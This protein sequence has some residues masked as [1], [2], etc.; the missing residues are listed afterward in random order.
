M[1]ILESLYLLNNLLH[2]EGIPEK[3]RSQFVG[4]CLLALKNGVKYE[5]RTT[6]EIIVS[7]SKTLEVLLCGDTKKLAVIC[8]VLEAQAI[9]SLPDESFR[10]ILRGID[11]NIFP[12]IY[13]KRTAGQN[14]LNFFFAIFNKYAGKADKNQIFTPDH[15][16][17][18][19]AKVCEVNRHSRVLDATCGSG[20]FL[21]RAM[22]QAV[23]D[24]ATVAEQE[25]VK[26]NHIF[27][28]EYDKDVFSLA[29]TNM[30]IYGDSNPNI[31][32]GSCFEFGDWIS[33]QNID[34]VLM[35]PPYNANRVQSNPGYVKGWKTSEDLS[36][37]FHFVDFVAKH[38]KTGKMAVLVPMQCAIGSGAE[39]KKFK[40]SMLE[41]HTLDAVF[42]LSN[43]LFYPG[44]TT[45]VCCMVF[46]LGK[47]H[48]PKRP[49]FFGYYKEDGFKK[50]K[51]RG[52]VEQR[53]DADGNGM[54]A[55]IE[56]KWLDLY[57]CM[58]EVDGLSAVHCVTASDEWLA[59]AYMK[60]DYSNLS[61]ADFQ[62]SLNDYLAYQ[63]K[64]GR[65]YES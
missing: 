64:E 54:W 9:E 10:K 47:R 42:T 31:L 21:I 58:R 5:D 60:T 14:L 1:D 8:K 32:Q 62:R 18:F 43:D 55:D 45:Q 25:E 38:V 29:I 59:E 26:K 41:E 3:L 20:S 39:T 46:T 56:E 15:I 13:D 52:R 34:V 53:I 28:I 7:I 17:D 23:D 30:L 16:T 11:E 57:H 33:E 65:I 48:N 4:T 6:S 22:T 19:M 2:I 40:K 27:G 51:N 37:G 24:C 49:T 35:N 36:K 63:V 12:F 61:E 50:R 44:A